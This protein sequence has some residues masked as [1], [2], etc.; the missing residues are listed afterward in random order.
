MWR[1]MD[2]LMDKLLYK[3]LRLIWSI[4]PLG[5]CPSSDSTY[6]FEWVGG[7]NYNITC[8]PWF[9]FGIGKFMQYFPRYISCI[10]EYDELQFKYAHAHNDYVEFFFEL[11]W[12]GLMLLIWLLTEVFIE[13]SKSLKTGQVVIGFSALV[14]YMVCAMGLFPRQWSMSR[15]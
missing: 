4:T 12:I 9:G 1:L 13:F 11:G 5:D 3:V 8:S 2:K 15:M 6:E 14:A 7:K 10:K